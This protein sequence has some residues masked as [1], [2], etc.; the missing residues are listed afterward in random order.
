MSTIAL[1]IQKTKDNKAYIKQISFNTFNID[2]R[3]HFAV[4]TSDPKHRIY[5][6]PHNSYIYYICVAQKWNGTEFVHH[7]TPDS[8][9]AYDFNIP[10]LQYEYTK[11]RGW[12]II[13][14]VLNKCYEP[15]ESE[16]VNF[17]E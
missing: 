1:N 5:D 13:P 11:L 7:I 15:E 2:H 6:E 16:L 14:M 4:W 3:Y 12:K 10:F 9:D 8:E 17:E